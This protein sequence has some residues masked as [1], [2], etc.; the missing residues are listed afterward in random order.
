MLPQ[1]NHFVTTVP[2]VCTVYLFLC[3]GMFL[4]CILR[5]ELGQGETESCIELYPVI[6]KKYCAPLNMHFMADHN[7]QLIIPDH[8]DIELS[9]FSCQT[10]NFLY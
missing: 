5:T 10:D 1:G 7:V 4:A 3:M 6:R 2:D 8:S 9:T